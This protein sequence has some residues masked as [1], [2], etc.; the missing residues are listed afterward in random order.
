M[1][2]SEFITLSLN[3]EQKNTFLGT[4]KKGDKKHENIIGLIS[5]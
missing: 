4:S 3:F 1:F 5:P 2:I